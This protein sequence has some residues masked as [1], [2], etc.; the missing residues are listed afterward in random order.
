MT[1]ASSFS[2]PLK[3]GKVDDAREILCEAHTALNDYV[4]RV[5][6]ATGTSSFFAAE[7]IRVP[8]SA[9]NHAL[10]EKTVTIGYTGIE[11]KF[12]I[13]IIPLLP[14]TNC[15]VKRDDTTL[16]CTRKTRV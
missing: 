16:E 6:P 5:D 12:P 2:N 14:V 4:C 10:P 15:K 8:T 7:R 1:R 13:I 11:S 3:F 9:I